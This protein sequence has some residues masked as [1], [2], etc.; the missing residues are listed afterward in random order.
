MGTIKAS[1]QT[2]HSSVVS[3]MFAAKAAPNADMLL[4]WLIARLKSRCVKKWAH[5][6]YQHADNSHQL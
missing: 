6:K 3:V 2:T 4:I 5:K 1:I